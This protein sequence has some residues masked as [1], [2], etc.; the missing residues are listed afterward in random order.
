MNKD[1]HWDQYK[2]MGKQGYW[3]AW[4]LVQIQFRV[5]ISSTHWSNCWTGYCVSSWGHDRSGVSRVQ[6]MRS[7][8]TYFRVTET[9]ASEVHRNDVLLEQRATYFGPSVFEQSG[10]KWKTHWIAKM[11][12]LQLYEWLWKRD[13]WSKI[14]DDGCQ[15]WVLWACTPTQ[16]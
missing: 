8:L 12:H 7:C 6:N 14:I 15:G 5:T 13:G 3:M 11:L 10:P 2:L 1:K 4:L 9:R 16:G